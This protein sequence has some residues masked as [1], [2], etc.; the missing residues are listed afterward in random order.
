MREAKEKKQMEKERIQRQEIEDEMK[1][2]AA[3]NQ[4]REAYKKEENKGN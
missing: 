2:H 3:L 1:I 4:M